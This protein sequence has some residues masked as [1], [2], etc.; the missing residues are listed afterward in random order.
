MACVEL[1]AYRNG[2]ERLVGHCRFVEKTASPSGGQ[3]LSRQA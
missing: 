3:G 1:F 2:S